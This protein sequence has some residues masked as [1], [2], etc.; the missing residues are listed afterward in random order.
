VQGDRHTLTIDPNRKFDLHSFAFS[1][2]NILLDIVQ[3]LTAT[4]EEESAIEK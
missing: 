3:E 1:L 4:C 2:F